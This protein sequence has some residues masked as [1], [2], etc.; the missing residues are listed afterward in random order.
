MS[1]FIK[2]FQSQ[3]GWFG[4]A[5]T[6]D[7]TLGYNLTDFDRRTWR[8]N[9]EIPLD[10]LILFVRDTS[11]WNDKNE[12]CVMTDRGIYVINDNDHPE[13]EYIILWSE[14]DNV[15]YKELVFYFFNGDEQIGGIYYSNLIKCED[16]EIRNKATSICNFLADLASMVEPEISP[17]QLA[18]D[19]KYE[20]AVSSAYNYVKSAPESVDAHFTL[21]RVL[22]LKNANAPEGELDNDEL[23]AAANEFLEALDKTEKPEEDNY[24]LYRNLAFTRELQNRTYQARDLYIAAMEFSSNPKAE[25]DE[26]KNCE[27][28]LSE[29]W[30]NYTDVYDYSN[31]KFCMPIRD[32]EIGGCNA[33]GIDVFRMSNIPKAMTFPTGHPYPGQL[34]IGHPYNKS[35]YVPY[36]QSEDIFFMDKVHE[37]CYL[38]ECLGAE[39]IEITSI[40]GKQVSEMNEAASKMSGSAD[41]KLFSGEGQISNSSSYSSDSSSKTSRTLTVRLDPMKLPY[42]PENLIWYSQQPQ[43]Q[44]LVERRINNNILEYSESVQSSDTRFTNSTEMDDIQASAKYLWVKIKANVEQNTKSQFR[45]STETVWNINVKFRSLKDFSNPVTSSNSTTNKSIE[46]TSEEKEYLEEYQLCLEEGGELSSKEL[47]MLDRMRIRLGMTEER[48]EELIQTLK[49]SYTTE[50][51]EFVDEIKACLEE[52]GVISDREMRMLDRMR[53]RLGI[54]E[55]RGKEILRIVTKS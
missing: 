34:Y 5:N 50:E 48:A 26:I 9:F 28:L 31:R 3:I 44:R 6:I 36:E 51:Q 12:G 45:E 42:L 35:L 21:G 23:D 18:E 1:D 30:D 39:Q 2:K 22:Y 49:P 43:W 10:E 32:F 52:D 14:F 20:E 54:S 53:S 4:T 46:L 24:V 33:T 37:L 40:K 13:D 8:S 29:T 16:S 17:I 47:R 11:F 19:G 38:L 41:L 27:Q 15:I 55:E 25:M 7:C